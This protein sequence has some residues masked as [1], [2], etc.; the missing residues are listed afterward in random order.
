MNLERVAHND[1]VTGMDVSHLCSQRLGES[2]PLLAAESTAPDS[3][4]RI[5]SSGSGS[6][7]VSDL[8]IDD[9]EPCPPLG[10]IIGEVS[11]PRNLLVKCETH[12]VSSGLIQ[13]LSPFFCP[14][15]P[16]SGST[17]PVRAIHIRRLCSM[18]IIRESALG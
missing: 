14:C 9:D 13:R 1:S 5:P 3:S 7:A 15:G 12:H 8:R 4:D 2:A 11:E 16:A 6:G 10:D 18:R 17:A